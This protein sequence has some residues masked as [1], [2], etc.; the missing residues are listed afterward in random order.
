VPHQLLFVAGQLRWHE[1]EVSLSIFPVNWNGSLQLFTR[2]PQPG[3][4]ND[5]FDGLE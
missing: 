5:S 1:V 2:K 4:Q 3:D